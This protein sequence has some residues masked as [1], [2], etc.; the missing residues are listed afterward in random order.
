MCN[1]DF[2][3]VTPDSRLMH[4]W[5]ESIRSNNRAGKSIG[6]HARQHGTFA[7]PTVTSASVAIVRAPIG[8]S[9]D[10]GASYTGET[11]CATGEDCMGTTLKILN[12]ANGISF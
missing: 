3:T 11:R 9:R 7:L 2:S 10:L 6:E 5:K 8:F 4:V 12:F 1:G